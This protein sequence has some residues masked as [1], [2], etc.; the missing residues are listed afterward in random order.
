MNSGSVNHS[1][2]IISLRDISPPLHGL[3]LL[4]LLSNDLFLQLVLI[5]PQVIFNNLVN[6]LPVLNAGLHRDQAFLLSRLVILLKSS[7]L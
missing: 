3:L 2:L 6:S 7:T 4:H 1:D 5:P